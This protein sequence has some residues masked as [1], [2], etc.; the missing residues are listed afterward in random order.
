MILFLRYI[1]NT[2]KEK[3]VRE[4]LLLTAIALSSGLLFGTLVWSKS[5]SENLENMYKEYY[6]GSDVYFNSNTSETFFSLNGINEQGISN[7]IPEIRITVNNYDYEEDLHINIIARDNMYNNMKLISGNFP[8]DGMNEAVISE[9]IAKK[10]GLNINDSLAFYLNGMTKEVKISGISVN[11]T[12][13][14]QDNVSECTALLSYTYLCNELNTPEKYN[15]VRANSDGKDVNSAI[16][17]FENNN[18]SFSAKMLYSDDDINEQVSK[19][20][21]TYYLMIVFVILITVTIVQGAKK[22]I[23]SERFSIIGTFFSQGALKKNVRNILLLEGIIEGI[24]GGILGLIIGY[25]FCIYINY[26]NSPLKNYGIYEKINVA[27]YLIPVP[28]IFAVLMSIISCIIPFRQIKNMQVK[29]VILNQ[30]NSNEMKQNNLYIIGMILFAA[31]TVVAFMNNSFAVYAS[32]PA[33]ICSF[34][35]L[36]VLYPRIIEW[37]NGALLRRMNGFGTLYVIINNLKTSKILMTNISLLLIAS[38]ALT[39]IFTISDSVK[40]GVVGIY[41]DLNYDV[42]CNHIGDISV[43]ELVNKINTLDY[44]DSNMVVEDYST[45]GT[46]NGNT[47]WLYGIDLDCYDKYNTYID[48]TSDKEKAAYESLKSDSENKIIIS[49]EVARKQKLNNKSTVKIS[50]NGITKEYTI[51]GI[52]NT[53]MMNMGN[54][55][56]IDNDQVHNVFNVKYP[57]GIYLTGSSSHIQKELKAKLKTDIGSYGVSIQTKAENIEADISQTSTLVSNLKIF[58][59]ICLVMSLFGVLNNLA[60]SFI[61][62]KREIA[63]LGS[64]GMIPKQRFFMLFGEAFLSA[65]WS[66]FFT[67]I[68]LYIGANLCSKITR[69]IGLGLDAKVKQGQIGIYVALIVLTGSLASVFVLIRNKKLTI[70]NEIRYE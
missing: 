41:E 45:E 20:V 3:K 7:M 11:E 62:R 10:L 48:F 69:L 37:I 35:G 52:I 26:E 58:G 36:L 59:I 14:T 17:L 42:V 66:A 56:Y 4:L 12:C 6:E 21:N 63:I 18:S 34:F 44:I 23:I 31:G 28:I 24:A 67:I 5:F 57:T 46:L 38:T 16:A 32:I 60:I 22:L 53:K 39:L 8:E 49:K 15:F 33:F 30:S 40:D 9:R 43:E 65:C 27:W 61:Q 54:G 25:F 50:I 13:F 70:I 29:E 64:I 47:Y 19:T 55:I 2:M 68:Y 51:A 1:L